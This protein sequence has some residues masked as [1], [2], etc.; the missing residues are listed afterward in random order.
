[1]GVDDDVS[2]RHTCAV[3]ERFSAYV[4]QR[5][6]HGCKTVCVYLHCVKPR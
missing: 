4:L 5:T 2:L 1:M 6:E 3:T